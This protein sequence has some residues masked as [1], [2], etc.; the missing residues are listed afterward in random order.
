ME[1]QQPFNTVLEQ[2]VFKVA[3]TFIELASPDDQTRLIN[4]V[5]KIDTSS[6]GNKPAEVPLNRISKP[7]INSLLEDLKEQWQEALSKPSVN[8]RLYSESTEVS[9]N[10]LMLM[11]KRQI[12]LATVYI[13]RLEVLIERT[14]STI[15]DTRL[16]AQLVTHYQCIQSRYITYITRLEA[17]KKLSVLHQ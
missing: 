7:H 3:A 15:R 8:K 14:K 17:A 16:Q 13:N 5:S 6:P 2:Y 1:Q 11:N 10:Q 9:I 4:L 12:E